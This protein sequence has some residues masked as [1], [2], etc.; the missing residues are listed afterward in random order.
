MRRASL[1]D[2]PAIAELLNDPLIR[3]SIGGE[4]ELDPTDLIADRNNVCLFDDRGGAMFVWRGPGIY[5][6]H[7]FFRVRGRDAIRL[8]TT[9]VHSMIDLF[10]AGMIWGATPLDNR[11]ARWFNRQLGFQSL[12]EIDRPESGRCELFVLE[13][14]PCL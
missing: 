6:G 8:G 12:G 1:D 11:S 9:L 2:V 3:P 10:G 4:G 5:E 14:D 13:S 7:S